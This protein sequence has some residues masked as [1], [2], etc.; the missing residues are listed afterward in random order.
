LAE[1]VVDFT[2]EVVLAATF[3][4]HHFPLELVHMMRRLGLAG[5]PLAAMELTLLS[6]A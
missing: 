1:V 3:G 2:V 5:L 6:V 4:G